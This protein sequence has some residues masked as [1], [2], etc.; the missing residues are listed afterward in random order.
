MR[1]GFQTLETSV[2]FNQK[3]MQKLF[4]EGLCQGQ[5]GPAWKS[6]PPTLSPGDGDFIR[7]GLK[8]RSVPGMAMPN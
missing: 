8:L 3:E 4:E 7:N 1:P 5:A 2:E 6:G